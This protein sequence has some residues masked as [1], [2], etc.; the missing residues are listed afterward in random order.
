M[1][2]TATLVEDWHDSK[3][4]HVIG[5]LAFSGNYST[6]GVAVDLPSAGIRTQSNPSIMMIPA[7][8]GFIFEYTPVTDASDGKVIVRG[9]GSVAASGVLTSDN[10][11]VSNNDT[12]TIGSRVYTF[13]T[14]LT[15]PTT[16]NE[17]HIGADADGSLT[18]LAAAINGTGTPGTDYGSATPVNTQVSSGAVAAHAI[19]VTALVAGTDGNAIATTEAAAHLSWGAATLAS[20]ANNSAN[21]SELSAAAFPTNL[22]SF[23]VPFYG[24]FL[25]G[26]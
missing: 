25:L 6:G 24:I 16:A 5:T 18:N 9:S 20:G 23:A 14:N 7:Y 26:Y 4:L 3:R 17:V 1:G 22:A 19:T 11:N 2:I 13:K 8:R 10:T 15:A 12:V 21:G